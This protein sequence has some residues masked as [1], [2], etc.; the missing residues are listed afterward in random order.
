MINMHNMIT[1]HNINNMININNSNNSKNMEPLEA[2]L[3]SSLSR[4]ALGHIIWGGFLTN[5]QLLRLRG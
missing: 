3:P 2:T 5:W 1:M 4:L